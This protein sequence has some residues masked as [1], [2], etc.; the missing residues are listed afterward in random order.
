MSVQSRALFHKQGVDL[1]PNSARNQGHKPYHAHPQNKLSSFHLSN[2]TWWPPLVAMVNLFK[3]TFVQEPIVPE[4]WSVIDLTFSTIDIMLQ[5]KL[6]KLRRVKWWFT[7]AIG[8][9]RPDNTKYLAKGGNKCTRKTA[10]HPP[11]KK[12]HFQSLFTRNL[13]MKR[14]NQEKGV[15]YLRQD[16]KSFMKSTIVYFYRFQVNV[17]LVNLKGKD[18]PQN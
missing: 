16:M 4:I 13:E 10:K 6:M 9:R 12:R 1:C 18:G 3:C 5:I 7:A 11:V 14:G 17:D 2:G 8:K 15:R